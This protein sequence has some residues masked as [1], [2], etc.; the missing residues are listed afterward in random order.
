VT[1]DTGSTGNVTPTSVT[2][3][4]VTPTSVTPTPG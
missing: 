3:T 2:P 1:A 4:S